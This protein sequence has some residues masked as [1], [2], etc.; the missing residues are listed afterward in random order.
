MR[1]F[2]LIIRSR[3]LLFHDVSPH[4]KPYGLIHDEG[5]EK[6][7]MHNQNIFQLSHRLNDIMQDDGSFITVLVVD[8]EV[9]CLDVAELFLRQERDIVVRKAQSVNEAFIWLDREPVDLIICDYEMPGANGIDFLIA[10][11]NG[12]H[13]TPFMILTG[14]GREKVAIKAIN[15][16]ADYYLKK[17]GNPKALFDDIRIKIRQLIQDRDRV[18]ILRDQSIKYREFFDVTPIAFILVN[19]LNGR[20]VDAN[21]AACRLFG[22]TR[23]EMIGLPVDSIFEVCC[24]SQASSVGHISS[25]SFTCPL[26]KDG[27]R[28]PAEITMTEV[29]TGGQQFLGLI[30]EDPKELR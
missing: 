8:D 19:R 5:R 18:R 30:I 6:M 23:N 13:D 17:D 25:Y 24:I 16:G 20:I 9:E 14:K 22:Y 4:R 2:R 1:F 28:F 10:L 11:R 12:G 3:F 27:S 15:H 7:Q 29:I 26:Q 21:R